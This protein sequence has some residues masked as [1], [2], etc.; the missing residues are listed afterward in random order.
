L[1]ERLFFDRINAKSRAFSIRGK[2]HLAVAVFADEAKTAVARP[3]MA[4]TGAKVADDPLRV[5]S[6]VVPP[7]AKARTVGQLA[8]LWR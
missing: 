3:Q 5:G 1:V 6:I 4:I 7:A 2:D 8:V